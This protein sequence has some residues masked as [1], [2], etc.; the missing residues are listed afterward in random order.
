MNSGKA[1]PSAKLLVSF[2]IS[3][4]SYCCEMWY[5]TLQLEL[6]SILS[7]LPTGI[8]GS[9]ETRL[10][11]GGHQTVPCATRL[12]QTFNS[13]FYPVEHLE[14][15]SC[16]STPLPPRSTLAHMRDAPLTTPSYIPLNAM[17]APDT[18]THFCI[19]QSGEESACVGCSPSVSPW[20]ASSNLKPRS[21]GCG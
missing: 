16:Q 3:W 11:C 2:H 1:I 20:H 21:V 8:Q 10:A 4:K 7:A 13:E 12:A 15:P 18:A 19:H 14:M 6:L 17:P 5:V 9:C